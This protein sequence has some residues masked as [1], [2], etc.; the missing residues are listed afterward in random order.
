MLFDSTFYTI[1]FWVCTLIILYAIYR[2]FA[3]LLQ[4]FEFGRQQAIAIAVV[5]LFTILMLEEKYISALTVIQ[6]DFTVAHFTAFGA[7]T[8]TMGNDSICTI[9]PK[10]RQ[11]INNTPSSLVLD[12]IQYASENIEKARPFLNSGNY[13]PTQIH[14]FVPYTI[15][16]NHY[17][18]DFWFGKPP[19]SISVQQQIDR[20]DRN[21]LHE[22]S[23]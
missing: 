11:I 5:A 4:R 12:Q 13:L 17:T 14:L 19:E 1:V 8:F 18:I 20:T 23:Y 2:V 3:R 16:D 10:R 15:E 22:Q 9:K 6:P 7:A 21:W